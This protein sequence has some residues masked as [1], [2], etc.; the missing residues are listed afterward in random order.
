MAIPG[1]LLDPESAGLE[2]APG[3][4]IADPGTPP[5]SLITTDTQI[6]WNGLLM[7]KGSWFGYKSL[8]GWEDLPGMDSAN[9]PRPRSHGAVPGAMYANEK[10]VTF[11]SQVWPGKAGFPVL[12]RE[13]LK[14]MTI[15]QVERPLIIRQHGETLVAWGRVTARSAPIDRKFFQG[16]PIFTVQWTLSDPRR[17]SMQQFSQM[18]ATP[19]SE[20]GLDWA[21]GLAWDTGLDWGTSSGG[22]MLVDNEGN[23]PAPLKVLFYGPLT[24][25]YALATEEWRMAFDLPLAAGEVLEVDTLQG[26]VTL[27]GVNR[28]HALTSNSDAIEDCTAPEGRTVLYFTSGDSTDEGRAAV[29]W[30]HAHM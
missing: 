9:S 11:E 10:A 13:W 20:G 29:Q 14:R 25:P 16:F 22:Q 19:S 6:E 4:I 27:N 7:G 18:T 2:D 5:G 12:R 24:A 1:V 26:S 23:T 3:V 8:E 30:R 28:Y 17:Y 15:E 21:G